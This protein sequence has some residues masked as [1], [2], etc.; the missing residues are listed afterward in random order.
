MLGDGGN[1]AGISLGLLGESTSGRRIQKQGL[2]H[3][4]AVGEGIGALWQVWIRRDKRGC[5]AATVGGGPGRKGAGPS[6]E[7]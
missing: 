6:K 3:V 5:R 1:E 7:G 2:S 4:T